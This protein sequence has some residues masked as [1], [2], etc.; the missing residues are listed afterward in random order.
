MKIIVLL[1]SSILSLP[2][3]PPQVVR[4]PGPGGAASVSA[5]WTVVQVKPFPNTCTA[6]T[7]CVTTI[8]STTAGNSLYVFVGQAGPS[9]Q[10]VTDSHSDTFTQDVQ[11]AV[12]GN[13]GF[14]WR[15]DNIVSGITTVTASNAFSDEYIGVVVEIQ[16]A[17]SSSS[18]D[19]GTSTNATTTTWTSGTT[20][21]LAAATDEAIGWCV[22]M[23]ETGGSYTNTPNAPFG[24]NTY[25]PASFAFAGY[26]FIQYL[27]AN[28]GTGSTTG[29]AAT[30][31]ISTSRAINCLV[32]TYKHS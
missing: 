21:T 2:I 4:I 32:A 19:Q 18:F 22:D 7:S 8:T 25:S 12:S 16:G 15:Y 30:G 9:G 14:A 6:G 11:A 27:T 31:T 23:N 1:L 17:V 5:T 28:T 10:S 20:A 3:F 29:I 26:G 24:N 13:Y